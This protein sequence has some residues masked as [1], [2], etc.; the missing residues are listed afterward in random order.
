MWAPMAMVSEGLFDINS[1]R[2]IPDIPNRRPNARD[3]VLRHQIHLRELAG[4]RVGDVAVQIGRRR[5]AA[6]VSV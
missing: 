6:S 2:S 4:P 1:I 5:S 3:H